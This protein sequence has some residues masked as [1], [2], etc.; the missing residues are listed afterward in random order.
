METIFNETLNEKHILNNTRA[1]IITIEGIDGSGKTTAVEQCVQLLKNSGY[2]AI[3][4]KTSSD[5]N[6]FWDIVKKGIS[7]KVIDNEVNQLIHNIAF[8][9]YIKSIFID[10]LNEYDYVVSEWYIYGKMVL[11][12]LYCQNSLNNT[13]LSLLQNEINLGNVLMPDFSFFIDTAPL[14]ARKRILERNDDLESKETLDML[15][16]A[17]YIWE[18]YINKYSIEKI[19]GNSSPELISE[20]ILRRVLSNEKK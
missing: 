16:K 17:Y 11:S 14:I 10:L 3:H 2:K 1:R 15:E 19:N 8:L 18:K 12:E 5:F 7:Y 13:A 4:F 6:T 9:T 20:Q